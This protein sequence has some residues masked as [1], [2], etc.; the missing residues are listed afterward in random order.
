MFEMREIGRDNTLDLYTGCIPPGAEEAG[1]EYA[2]KL[3]IPRHLR[4]ER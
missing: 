4:R 3:V 2:L 1:R